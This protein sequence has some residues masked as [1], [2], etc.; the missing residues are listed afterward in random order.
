MPPKRAV[1]HQVRQTV[2]TACLISG[3]LLLASAAPAAGQTGVWQKVGADAANIRAIAIDPTDSRRVYAAA[4]NDG[5][6]KSN[7][8]GAS[9]SQSNRGLD[10]IAVWGVSVDPSDPATV[11]AATEVGGAYVSRDFGRSWQ[12]TQEGRTDTLE[13]YSIAN[14]STSNFSMLSTNWSNRAPDKVN[15]GGVWGYPVDQCLSAQKQSNAPGQC[16]ERAD[17][18][19]GGYDYRDPDIDAAAPGNQPAPSP[20]GRHLLHFQFTSDVLALPGGAWITA[21]RGSNNSLGG[22]AFLTSDGGQTWDMMLRQGNQARTRLTLGTAGNL[23]K[24]R[25]APSDPARVYLASTTGVWLSTDGGRTWV[26]GRPRPTGQ[27]APSSPERVE[28]FFG[29]NPTAEVRG[30]AVDIKDADIVYSGTWGAGV[31]KS[32]DGGRNWAASAKGLP[33][34]AGVWEIAVNPKDPNNLFAALYWH[35]V[36]Q[37][38]DAGASWQPY[39]EGFSGDITRQVYSLAMDSETQQIYAGTIDGV[40]MRPLTRSGPRLAETGK[41][42]RIALV[43]AVLLILASLALRTRLRAI[44]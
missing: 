43:A 41:P 18:P 12:S 19:V 5:V 2:A 4:R 6:W 33:A 15:R 30:L 10:F 1:I 36:Y 14:P 32:T 44:A 22:G 17:W 37:S 25:I 24:I 34:G 8:A 20:Y 23:Y 7:D 13:D 42:N 3:V 16:A 29:G 11:W 35:G 9:W 40:W 38:N 39:N 31:T 28:S 27:T 26:D 21:F